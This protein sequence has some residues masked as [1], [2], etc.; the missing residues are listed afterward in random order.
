MVTSPVWTS[1]SGFSIPFWYDITIT[2]LQ[3]NLSN[4][5]HMYVIVNKLKKE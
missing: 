2:Y 4:N 1:H 5:V 3:N